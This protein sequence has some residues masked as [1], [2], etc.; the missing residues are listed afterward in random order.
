MSIAAR[1]EVE[2][3]CVGDVVTLKAGGGSRMTVTALT[4]GGVLC[5]WFDEHG[6]FRQEAF[7]RELLGHEPRSIS[8]GLVHLRGYVGAI[9]GSFA[10][11]AS[12]AQAALKS[13]L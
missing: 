3:F 13:S 5:Q 12:F 10:A 2:H 4:A 8:P 11:G 9:T 7:A 1:D 6:E